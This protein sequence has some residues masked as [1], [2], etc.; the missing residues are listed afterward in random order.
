[1]NAVSR[2]PLRMRIT[3]GIF[4]GC[5]FFL[6]VGAGIADT[7]EQAPESRFATFNGYKIHYTIEGK[8]R[9][10]LLFVHG[11]CCD[12]SAWRFQ[13][14]A[15]TGDYRV[16]AVDLIGHGKSDKPKIAYTQ[17][18]FADALKAVV[19]DAGIDKVF[20]IG[21]SMGYPVSE[22]F[23][24]SYPDR[25][26][27]ICIVDG[28]Y[29]RIPED[30]QEKAK[31]EKELQAFSD[32]FK[33]EGR[34]SFLQTF[35]DSLFIPQS[36]PELK[37]EIKNLMLGAPDYVA[38]SAMDEMLK[39]RNWEEHSLSAPA[40]AV[41]AVSDDMP[42]DNEAYLRKWFPDLEYHLWDDAGHFL[43][44]ERPERFNKVLNRFL[45]SRFPR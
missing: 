34:K 41:Y 35:L 10:T 8:G 19:D 38:D 7:S 21:H 42:P 12:I 17:Q 24:R 26:S 43:M 23:T 32:L 22:L 25:V 9:Q 20:L 27:G 3:A 2:R 30:P 5:F 44:M 11:W 6:G 29:L 36:P 13:K 4:L 15:F 16:I 28:A 40:L 18:L 45:S 1:M 37:E 31:Y 39:F 33:G 14:P